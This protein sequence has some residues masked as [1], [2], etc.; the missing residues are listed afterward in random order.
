LS[1]DVIMKDGQNGMWPTSVWIGQASPNHLANL[2]VG[3][4]A[5][6]GSH[7]PRTRIDI[8]TPDVKPDFLAALTAAAAETYS[9]ASNRDLQWHHHREIWPVGYYAGMRYGDGLFRVVTI[10]ESNAPEAHRDSGMIALND[11]RVG[12][13][14]VALPGL[15]WGRPIKIPANRGTTLILPG[16]LSWSVAPLRA[17]HSMV[18]FLAQ[19][20]LAHSA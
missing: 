4:P 9:P 2:G 11:P 6:T 20:T 19:A 3:I 10:V 15:P 14:N 18:V 13:A 1:G 8:D 17:P 5:S 16:W 7:P 12:A